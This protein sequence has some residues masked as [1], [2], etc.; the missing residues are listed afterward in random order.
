MSALVLFSLFAQPIDCKFEWDEE[1]RLAYL[2][3]LGQNS[4]KVN[5]ESFSG[6]VQLRENDLIHL[7]SHSSCKLSHFSLSLFSTCVIN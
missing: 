1:H 6:P 5:G 7:F 3:N 4:V 2:T